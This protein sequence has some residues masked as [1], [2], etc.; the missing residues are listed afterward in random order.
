MLLPLSLAIFTS[1][2]ALFT[3]DH[4]VDKKIHCWGDIYDVLEGS[5]FNK[6][7]YK[8][9]TALC[10]ASNDANH[11][12]YGCDCST[13]AVQCHRSKANISMYD[14]EVW[15]AAG[16]VSM[17]IDFSWVCQSDCTCNGQP[18][19]YLQ[20]IPQRMSS[21]SPAPVTLSKSAGNITGNAT[22]PFTSTAKTSNITCVGPMPDID[23]R[24]ADIQSSDY[25]DLQS[26]CA[27]ASDGHPTLGCDCSGPGGNA[28]CQSSLANPLL[29]NGIQQPP[30][31]RVVPVALLFL[32]QNYCFCKSQTSTPWQ[33]AWDE[34]W[35]DGSKY[36]VDLSNNTILEL[37][38]TGMGRNLSQVPADEAADLTAGIKET[39]LEI[40]IDNYISQLA[41]STDGT[42][43]ESP[44]NI[45]AVGNQ[46]A[47]GSGPVGGTAGTGSSN[48]GANGQS[49]TGISG[50]AGNQTNEQ[51][52][53]SAG[54]AGFTGP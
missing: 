52:G 37:M 42:I 18:P 32:C 30:G 6:A 21:Q 43:S 49:S 28:T 16:N 11:P 9:Y 24:N 7:D 34:I 23:L 14:F 46:T 2:Q 40:M 39:N 3:N 31:K 8:D 13:G 33:L 5:S 19:P 27:A 54:S 50:T 38:P 35:S 26:L 15:P 48:S 22:R 36:G 10:A 47:A 44:A 12:T 20:T 53:A 17:P 25:T 1:A 45:T 4:N 51:P 41:N 29:Y